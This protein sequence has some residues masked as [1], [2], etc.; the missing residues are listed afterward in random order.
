VATR[1]RARSTRKSAPKRAGQRE[2][3]KAATR[4][5][6]VDAALALFSTKGFEATST[7]Q[8]AKRARIA[9]GTVF[10]YFE[11]KEDIALSFFEL[12]TD[13]A[14][15][16]VRQR[17]SLA[18]APLEEK[19]FALIESQIEFLAP[20]ERFIGAA[21]VQALKPTSKLG[22]SA[23]AIALRQRYLAFV[24]ELMTES[25][26][27]GRAA[28]AGWWAPQIF[29]IFYVGVLLYW[30][31][32]DSPQKQNTLAFLDRSLRVGVAMLRKGTV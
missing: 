2:R 25:L 29:W 6:I 20:H 4:Q 28:L 10:N 30:L 1:T 18:K 26:P 24:E 17:K 14:I 7:K 21:F 11:T 15:A 9:E 3:N 23:Q 12:E 31:H 5:R 8:I 16:T 22:F 32:D 19:L 13:H 27:D